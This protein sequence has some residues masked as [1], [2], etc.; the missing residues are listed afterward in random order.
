MPTQ[1]P[2]KAAEGYP[3]NA[4][5]LFTSLPVFDFVMGEKHLSM[6]RDANKLVFD[7]ASEVFARHSLTTEEIRESCRDLKVLGARELKQLV[8][9]REKMRRFLEEV[10]SDGEE[11]KEEKE[12]GAKEEGEGLDG[13]D[14]KV[15]A[16]A[17][18]ESAAVKRSV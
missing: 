5:V 11:G 8:K 18:K 10:G 16:L 6:L 7:R 15:K 3:D 4:R 12:G 14:D 1:K 2:S 17:S 13:I 9:W